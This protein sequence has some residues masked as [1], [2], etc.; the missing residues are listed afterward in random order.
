[1]IEFKKVRWKNFLSTGNQWTE[2]NFKEKST[3]LIVGKNGSGKSTVLDA[4]TF[5]LFNKPFRKINKPQLPNSIN[6]KDCLVEVEFSTNNTNW[7][8]RRGM[9]PNIFE[10]HRNGTVL[11]QSA[12]VKDDQKFLENKVLKLNYKS[13]TQ[14]VILGSST[15]I[16]F[17]QLPLA[18]RREII[19][20]L[21]DI[22]IFSTMNSILKDRLKMTQEE[23]KQLSNKKSLIDEKILMQ[24]NFIHELDVK[25][26]SEI[27]RKKNKIIEIQGKIE[28]AEKLSNNL[29]KQSEN[30]DVEIQQYANSNS[31]SKKLYD[32]RGKLQNKLDRLIKDKSFFIDNETCPTCS[33]VIDNEVKE[34]KIKE[35]DD[36]LS[37][38][39]SG[40][41]ELQAEL[42]KTQEDESKL[43]ELS[44]TLSDLN[45][46]IRDLN[47]K[48][49]YDLQIIEDIKNEIYEIEHNLE[50]KT[51]ESEKLNIF[52]QEQDSIA[53][54]LDKKREDIQ[55]HEFIYS[56]LK[57]NGVK[58]K[59][60]KN[61]LPIINQ[62]VNRFLHMMD[63]YINFN[64]DEE[65]N[66]SVKTPIH[67]NFS[68]ESF[69]EGEK[70]RIDL[71]LVFTWREIARMKNSVNTNLLILDEIFDSSLDVNGTDDFL[72]IIRYIIKDANIF[73]ISHKSELHDK[74]ESVIR[75]EKI[76]GFSRIIHKET[77]DK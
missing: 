47:N 51:E 20:D 8:I 11:E 64:F 42:K 74:F 61:Y 54:K 9:K 23:I 21:L 39:E 45:K 50:N 12:E 43:V 57:D 40:L 34:T 30:I 16:P 63:F 7:L 62:Q 17:M 4:L 22:K 14:I 24:Q 13:F 53:N 27:T 44:T 28:D 41:K 26:Q 31:K 2:I 68:Y 65:F 59:I 15:F 18:S 73:V 46:Q 76:K 67:E 29:I 48:C 58:S 25:G 35:H 6:E 52:K 75:F 37:E 55:Y 69:S 1:M 32:L 3:T 5:V 36:S 19:E 60:I 56:L 49:K 77:E 72:K 10:I 33:Q 66:E 38:V 71:A 70:Q